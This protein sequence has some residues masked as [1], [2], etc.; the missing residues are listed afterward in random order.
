MW[1]RLKE[2][3]FIPG[4]DDEHAVRCNRQRAGERA[5]NLGGKTAVSAYEEHSSLGD[6]GWTVRYPSAV[7]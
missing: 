5:Y 1:C 4:V 6:R 2:Q 3:A 7:S